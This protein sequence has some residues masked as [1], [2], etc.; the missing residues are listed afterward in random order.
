MKVFDADLGEQTFHVFR[1]KD[2]SIVIW[3]AA[4]VDSEC[5]GM[6]WYKHTFTCEQALNLSRKL[7]AVCE[8]E[9]DR[10]SKRGA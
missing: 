2:G 8:G 4:Y 7:G 3:A 6:D 5:E 10:L 9:N 1:E